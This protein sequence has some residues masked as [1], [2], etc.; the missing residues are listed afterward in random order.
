MKSIPTSQSAL[1]IIQL[2]TYIDG[3]P[4]DFAE[5]G[6]DVQGEGRV[7]PHA[8]R[9]VG[10]AF[11]NSAGDGRVLSAPPDVSKLQPLMNAR[12]RAGSKGSQVSGLSSDVD[13]GEM[14]DDGLTPFFS[15][16]KAPWEE[17]GVAVVDA[18][19]VPDQPPVQSAQSSGQN[20][21][22]GLAMLSKLRQGN[23]ANDVEKEQIVQPLSTT[24]TSNA[25]KQEKKN[26]IDKNIN[27]KT[28]SAKKLWG[29]RRGVGAFIQFLINERSRV[30]VASEEYTAW[31]LTSGRIAKKETEGTS[32]LWAHDFDERTATSSNQPKPVLDVFMT[33]REITAKSQQEKLSILPPLTGSNQQTPS[34]ASTKTP[35]Q[36]PEPR[37]AYSSQQSNLN[38]T[39]MKQWVQQLPKSQPTKEFGD[40]R[41]DVTAIMNSMAA[42]ETQATR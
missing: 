1:T 28:H 5:K 8:F 9:V 41:L 26:S 23:A 19:A 30:L 42:V 2:S 25:I 37:L 18:A 39:W 16:G 3:N 31:R 40:F 32:W 7:D 15:E 10:G 29:P 24:S 22:K 27:K 36:Q 17:L 12:A 38:L 21:S 6:F 20:N 4:H 13:G 33:D 35:M 34:S 14:D 11:M